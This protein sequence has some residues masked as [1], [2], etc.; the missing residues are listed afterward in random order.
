M[1]LFRNLRLNIGNKILRIRV[2]KRSRDRKFKNFREVKSIGVVWNASKQDEFQVLSRFN[3]KMQEIDV[4]VKILGYY[5]GKHLPDQYTALRYL[6]CIRNEET[7]L[8]Y[9]PDSTDVKSFI[10]NKFD[11]LIDINF[12]NIFTLKYITLLSKAT[13]K[14][15]LFET[16]GNNS[17]FDLMMEMKKP[18]KV[19]EYLRQVIQYLEM[20]NS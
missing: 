1:E 20:I 15:G 10:G 2:S 18:V 17:A 16:E 13:F 6:T 3:Q 19:E 5:H 7:N 14:I 4:D 12:E 8:F 11:I 9:I